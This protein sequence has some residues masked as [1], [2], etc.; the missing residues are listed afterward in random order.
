MKAQMLKDTAQSAALFRSCNS[1][2]VI[3]KNLQKLFLC[4]EL[5]LE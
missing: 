5:L 4:M 2:F 1:C 3:K